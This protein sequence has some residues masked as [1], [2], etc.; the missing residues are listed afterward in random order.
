[1]RQ[2]YSE[3]SLAQPMQLVNDRNVIIEKRETKKQLNANLLTVLK[4]SL[5]IIKNTVSG[6][7]SSVINQQKSNNQVMPVTATGQL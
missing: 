7:H 5:N 2:Y 4:N 6:Y 1:M 3:Q